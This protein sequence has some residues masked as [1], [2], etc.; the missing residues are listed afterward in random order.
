M[1]LPSVT[2]QRCGE[3]RVLLCRHLQLIQSQERKALLLVYPKNK[4][5]E[6]LTLLLLLPEGVRRGVLHSLVCSLEE[7]EA[8]DDLSIFLMM[9]TNLL[10]SFAGVK[11]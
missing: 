11:L 5:S 3:Q 9:D 2:R 8:L 4:M 10:N 7:E 6:T 1:F